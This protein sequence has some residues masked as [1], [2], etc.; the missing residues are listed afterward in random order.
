VVKT[1]IRHK[2]KQPSIS[3]KAYWSVPLLVYPMMNGESQ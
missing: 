3:M 1:S 2:S